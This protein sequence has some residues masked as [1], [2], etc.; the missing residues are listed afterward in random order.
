MSDADSQHCV[1]Q[2]RKEKKRGKKEASQVDMVPQHSLQWFLCATALTHGMKK[3][4]RCDRVMSRWYDEKSFNLCIISLRLWTCLVAC[5][6]T[7]ITSTRENR[8]RKKK[9][10]A[11][12]KHRQCRP[13]KLKEKKTRQDGDKSMPDI[14]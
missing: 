4:P 9:G 3:G 8:K 10:D 11:I 5:Q 14:P 7:P 1:V 12:E 6:S 2:L 13:A